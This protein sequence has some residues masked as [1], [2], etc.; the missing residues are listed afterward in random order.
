MQTITASAD[1]YIYPPRSQDAIPREQTDIFQMLGWIAQYKYND[2]HCLIKYCP[3][4]DIQL[5][6]RHAE[7]FRTYHLPD[8]I[9]QQLQDIG[10][11]IGHVAGN[12]TILDGGLLDQKHRAIKDTIVIWDMLVHN[13]Q[14]LI[15]STYQSRYDQLASISSVETWDYHHEHH[16]PVAFGCKLS[17]DVFMPQNIPAPQW[18]YAWGTIHLVNAPYTVGMPNQPNY[19]CRPVLEGLVFKDPNGVL[20]MGFREKN[21]D[22]WMIRSRVCTGR[23]NF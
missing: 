6:N 20:E 1:Q 14:H 9:Q 15:G 18:D 22:A 17:E 13:N 10:Q 7:R 19:Q 3:N 5:W 11:R 8:H 23:H 16:A 21:N 2:S 4:G 12:L